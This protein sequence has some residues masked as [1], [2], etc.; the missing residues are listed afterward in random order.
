[1]GRG[2]DQGIAVWLTRWG[3]PLLITRVYG[4]SDAEIFGLWG[5]PIVGSLR[6]VFKRQRY[7][8]AVSVG[9]CMLASVFIFCFSSFGNLVVC[10]GNNN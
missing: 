10:G 8:F 3:L 1:M 5:A 6:L 2:G 9:D 4:S 7:S